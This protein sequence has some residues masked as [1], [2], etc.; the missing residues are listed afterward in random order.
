MLKHILKL[1]VILLC[2]SS[3]VACSDE[4]KLESRFEF[5]L[6]SF[7][8]PQGDDEWDHKIVEIFETYN[9][10][11]IY[12]D[13]TSDDLVRSWTGGG[14]VSSITYDQLEGNELLGMVNEIEKRVFSYT[15]A[16]MRNNLLPPY[17]YL[18]TNYI[19][20]SLPMFMGY[21]LDGMD[22]WLFSHTFDAIPSMPGI[23]VVSL[24]PNQYSQVVWD[25]YEKSL[26]KKVFFIPEKFYE[27]ID[28]QTPFCNTGSNVDLN[29]IP[30]DIKADPNFYLNRGFVEHSMALNWESDETKW[31]HPGCNGQVT[32]DYQMGVVQGNNDYRAFVKIMLIKPES[33][34]RERYKGYEKVLRRF[35]ILYKLFD[36]M[37]VNLHN[38]GILE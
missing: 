11:I 26:A 16:G 9:A 7:E 2:V 34:I 24:G 21:S 22:N 33:F 1:A 28:Y 36:D 6:G 30:E 14:D 37:G 20:P 4:D 17:I 13:I 19:N 15:S 23:L 32:Q 8:F 27:D 12:K 10:R 3:L 35:D 25:I 38:G 29:K 18:V 31:V 5:Q